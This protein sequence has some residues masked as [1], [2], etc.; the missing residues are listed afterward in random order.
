M[1]TTVT[2]ASTAPL[3]GTLTSNGVGSGLDIQGLVQKLVA[4][5]GAPKSARLDSAEADAQAK[6]SALGSLR[7]ALSSFQD[8]VEKLKSVDAFSTRQVVA[9]SKDF[10]TA[11]AGTSA[12][13][14]TYAVEVEKLAQAQKLQSQ[15]VASATAVGTGT[16]TITSGGENFDIDIDST[17][18][19]IAGIAKAINA[20]PAGQDVIATVITGTGGTATLTLTARTTGAANAI[21]VTQSGGD[22][23]LAALQYPPS[24]GIGLAQVTQASDALAKIEGVEVTSPT[25]TISD[26]I[27]GVSITLL[28]QNDPGD[29]STFAVQ[30]D[31][32]AA[33]SLIN[34]FVKA[35]NGVVDAVKSVASYDAN[36]KQAG[37]LFGDAGVVNIT[38][39]LRRTLSSVVPGVDS[40]LNMLAKVGVTADVDGHLSVDATKLDTAFNTSF[41]DVGKL[42]ADPQAGL[43]AKLDTM[44]TPYLQ[45]GGVFDSRN[46]SLKASIADIDDQRTQLNNRLAELQ[47]RYTKQFNALDTLLSQ[48]QSTSNFLTQQ[49]ASL[50]GFTFNDGSKKSS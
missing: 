16:L 3:T 33:K 48:L 32:T 17:N 19:T 5:E 35:Y 28:E 26:A 39:Q 8:A 47:D 23:G 37:P 34:A 2:G 40:S 11:T 24:G 49:L 1:A 22:G 36:A 9:S 18:N 50:P 6:L 31:E 30:T 15:P 4:A 20:S 13:P 45:T 21:T 41:E 44:L 25:N 43:A 42:F 38:D 27:D 12:L 7:S 14:A 29:T 10:F 46:D